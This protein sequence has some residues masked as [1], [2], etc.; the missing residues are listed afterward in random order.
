VC[1]VNRQNFSHYETQFAQVFLRQIIAS[2]KHTHKNEPVEVNEARVFS[3]ILEPGSCSC[4]IKFVESPGY[5]IKPSV[6]VKAGK[7]APRLYNQNDVL[8]IALAWWLFQSG[9][10]SQAIGRVLRQMEVRNILAASTD[11]N[12]E[13]ASRHYL[14]VRR[15]MAKEEPPE[16]VVFEGD[17]EKV[18]AAI[19][20]TVRCGF[21][22][23]PIGSLLS[24]L[25]KRLRTTGE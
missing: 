6:R 11:W 19:K 25:W 13:A 4:V 12:P 17:L 2:K 21:Q 16:Q 24:L 18:V 20:A 22:I 7:G 5:G 8:S 10:R 15:E 1:N 14:V 3:F 9:F 23:L